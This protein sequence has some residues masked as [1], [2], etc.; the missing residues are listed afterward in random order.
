MECIAHLLFFSHKLFFS[1]QISGSP[2][3]EIWQFFISH[4]K[5]PPPRLPG[6]PVPPPPQQ[7][8]SK[9][10][11]PP[12]IFFW[13]GGGHCAIP[14][15]NEIHVKQLTFLHHVLSLD[16]NDPVRKTYHQQTKFP[17]EPN[18]A[19]NSHS[20][21]FFCVFLYFLYSRKFLYFSVF[22]VNSLY[23]SVFSINYLQK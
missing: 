8:F 16:D 1:G 13:G 3:I 17:F 4:P 20:S 14:I 21:V 18:W 19:N 23:Y 5:L 7:I 9:F 11:F 10:W 22:L 12:T 15:E 2:P 6:D